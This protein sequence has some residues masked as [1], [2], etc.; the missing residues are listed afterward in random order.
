MDHL[1]GGMADALHGL[2]AVRAIYYSR[3]AASDCRLAIGRHHW[4]SFPWLMNKANSGF[5]L[6]KPYLACTLHE[7]NFKRNGVNYLFRRNQACIWVLL[8]KPQF[9]GQWKNT[10]SL[11]QKNRI[12]SREWNGGSLLPQLLIH[13]RRISS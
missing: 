5:K 1:F 6:Q 11:D 8:S 3:H 13:F 4:P 12:F 10:V 9:S 2:K 7:R